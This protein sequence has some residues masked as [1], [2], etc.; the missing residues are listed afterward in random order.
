[1]SEW[2]RER[3]D[4]ADAAID[5]AVRDIMSAEPRPGFRHRVLGKLREEARPSWTWA[6]AA[7]SVFGA[8]ALITLIVVARPGDRPSEPTRVVERQQPQPTQPAVR[9]PRPAEPRSVATPPATRVSPQ[10]RI[11]RQAP[12][13]DAR[14]VRAASLPFDA[15]GGEQIP[16]R[17]RLE[18]SVVIDPIRIGPLFADPLSVPQVTVSPLPPIDRITIPPLPPPR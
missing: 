13:S 12:R 2:N 18:S 15:A 8:V 10:P 7:V 3:P 17:P 11:D 16:D 4:P 9:A 1:M 5:R 14:I 6:R